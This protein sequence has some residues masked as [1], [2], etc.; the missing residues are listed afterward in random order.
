MSIG[1]RS[2]TSQTRQT[3]GVHADTA[4][5]GVS[6]DHRGAKTTGT[7]T[8]PTEVDVDQSGAGAASRLVSKTHAQAVL[9]TLAPR[10]RTVGSTGV[11]DSGDASKTSKTS[12][13]T[14]KS[15]HSMT[16][17]VSMTAT[18]AAV[19]PHVTGTTHSTKTEAHPYDGTTA[20]G[21]GPTGGATAPGQ[22]PAT[23]RTTTAAGQK[24]LSYRR[25]LDT[26]SSWSYDEKFD[27]K[28][29]LLEPYHP[30]DG[31]RIW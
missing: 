3:V 19:R 2:H 24:P 5:T 18:I 26:G 1:D 17:A 11:G 28:S 30:E 29:I 13:H 10:E 25:P 12:R 23:G 21:Q 31:E 27:N 15:S 20:P 14:A 22:G 6:S 4:E 7:S 9:S 16:P 8:T